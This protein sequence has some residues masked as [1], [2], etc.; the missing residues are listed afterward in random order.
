MPFHTIAILSGDRQKTIPNRSDSEV[1]SEIVIPF[2][3]NGVITAKWGNK[4]QSYQVLELRIYETKTPWN[5]KSG[6]VI[7]DIIKGK[8]N[9]YGR[10]ATKAEA[11]L[12][13][14]K[15]KVF[16]ITPIQ[17]EKHGDQEQQRIFREYDQRFEAVEQVISEAGAIAIRIDKEHAL[18]DL[19]GRIKKEIRA[20]Q[21]VVADLTDERP[22]CYFEAG[23]AEA[24]GK[25]VI[26]VASKQSVAKPGTKTAIH[27][28]IHMN[29]NYFTNHEELKEKLSNAIEKNRQ[30]LFEEG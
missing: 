22:S 24:L 26:Y 11:L 10:F 3:A 17:G 16:V 23:F 28:D 27:F 18:E 5:K 4:L 7:A 30:A 12:S 15:P 21:F 9:L 8:K 13:T 14:K 2:I 19:V 29:M 20:A 6:T 1:L 25:K